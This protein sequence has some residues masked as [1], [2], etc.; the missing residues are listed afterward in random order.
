MNKTELLKRIDAFNKRYEDKYKSTQKHYYLG[1]VDSGF[2]IRNMVECLDEIE[3]KEDSIVLKDVINRL[4]ELPT[5]DRLMWMK[6]INEVF[7]NKIGTTQQEKLRAH[8]L[9]RKEM[10][11]KNQ[12]SNKKLNLWEELGKLHG[13]GADEAKATFDTGSK[14]ANINYL[15]VSM[16]IDNFLGQKVITNG[17]RNS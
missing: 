5:Y 16:F 6:K 13:M 9:K 14:V 8:N 4:N 2:A 10:Q 17:T 1:M 7:G 12:L 11:R 3:T 15:E